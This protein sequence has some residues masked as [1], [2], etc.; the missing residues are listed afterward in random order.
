MS[1]RYARVK[2]REK[3]ERDSVRNTQ[4]WMEHTVMREREIN[5]I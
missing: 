3:R 5:K 1:I 2:D 4:W